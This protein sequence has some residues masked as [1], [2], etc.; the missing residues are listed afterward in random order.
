MDA[1]LEPWSAK[2]L[3]RRLGAAE[4]EAEELSRGVEETFLDGSGGV[5]DRDDGSRKGE[6]KAT[7][8]ELADFCRRYREGRAVVGRRREWRERWDEGRVGGWR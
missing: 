4:R 2:A 3:Y 5:G 6:D 8:R 7:E 1:V